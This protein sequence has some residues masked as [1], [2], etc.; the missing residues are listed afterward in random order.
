MIKARKR[1]LPWLAGFAVVASVAPASAALAPTY[2]SMR[3]LSAI[4]DDHR[5]GD[6][7]V[8]PY[9]GIQSITFKDDNGNASYVFASP[10]CSVTVHTVYPQPTSDEEPGDDNFTLKFDPPVCK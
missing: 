6:V 9:P 1:M 10:N 5:L 7:L 8:G 4:L 2:E 3:W